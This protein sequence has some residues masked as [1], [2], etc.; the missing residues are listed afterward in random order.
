MNIFIQAVLLTAMLTYAAIKDYQ[1]R[2][3]PECLCIGISFLCILDFNAENLLG[4]G[5]PMI[6]L[7]TSTYI[8]PE[9][10][11]GG[12]IKLCAATSI[13]IGFNAVTYGIIIAFSVVSLIFLAL[14]MT[15]TKQD[16]SSYSLP[17]A[18]YLAAGFLIAYFIKLGGIIV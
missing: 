6:L 14:K 8:C 4:L 9:R 2:E 3:I 1:T 5:I 7:I 15:R 17:L 18:P 12:D 16:V 10:L 13:V 11:G